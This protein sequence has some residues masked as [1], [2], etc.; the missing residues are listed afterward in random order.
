MRCAAVERP[1]NLMTAPRVAAHFPQ[2]YASLAKIVGRPLAAHSLR[3]AA[4]PRTHTLCVYTRNHRNGDASREV[5]GAKRIAMRAHYS[6]DGLP[7]VDRVRHW[8]DYFAQQVH[9]F[10]PG[11]I[12]NAGAF[13]AE[14]AGQAVGGFALL[15]IETGL[16]RALRTHA[17]VL[18]DKTEAIYI[19]RFR[20]P[21]IWKAR[22]GSTPIDL[23]HEPGDF[24]V[25]STEWQFDAESK[26]PASFRVLVIPHAAL[27]PLLAGGRLTRPFRLPAASPLGSLLSA[28][29]DAANMQIPLLSDELGEAVLRNLTGLVALACG[30]SDEGADQG[31]QSV[32]SSQL[33][34]VKRYVDLHLANPGLTP[35]SAAAA[36]G[37]SLRQLHRLF[38]PTGVSFARY[39]LRQRLLK[40]RDAV[41][42]ATGTGRSIVDIAFGWGF[43]S[44]ATFYRAF[45]S[46]FGGA[47]AVLR[48]ASRRGG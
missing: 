15:D 4:A 26:G 31:R 6:T 5:V 10:T 12:P 11:E 43:N 21:M 18:R 19:R 45:T 27:S 16:E 2:L 24:G 8:C 40:C 17:D 48:A 37:V 7:P 44:M 39:V 25:S 33:A 23:E 32:R 22:S 42:G 20:R 38:E 29:I 3:P 13:R 14:A 46:E 35:A 47:P 30:A 9:S 28:A 1:H 34:A 36:L 41:A